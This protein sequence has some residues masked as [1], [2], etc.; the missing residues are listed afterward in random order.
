MAK[1]LKFLSS[2]ALAAVSIVVT[3]CGGHTKSEDTVDV[4]D[5]KYVHRYGVAVPSDF[6]AAS[7]EH[8]LVVSTLADGVVVTR[9]YAS[10]T[11]DGET[12]FT[13]PHSSQI[14]K[15]QIYQ[16]GTLVQET[17][18]FFDGTPKLQN[19]YHSPDYG[20]TS[21]YTWYLSG[22]PKSIERYQDNNLMTGEYFTTLNQR[23]SLVEDMQG[24]R[25]NR[26]D[27]GQLQSTDI[28]EN[29]QMVLR[30][31]Y[32][33]NGSPRE[34]I[35]Y[36]NGLIDGIKRTYHPAGEPDTIEQW[37]IGQQDGMTVVFQ[38]GEKYSE[39]PYYNGEKHGVECRYR[40]GQDKVKEISWHSGQLNGPSTT[41]VGD[42]I[43]TDWYY[44]G[45]P[46]SKADYEFITNRPIVR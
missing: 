29:G 11:L 41:Y 7:G 14:Q 39:V 18:Y 4:I 6:W 31:T 26:D 16:A 21:M 19:I 25:L 35:P 15:K 2:A 1:I 46:V 23:D 20:T 17:E 34:T 32:H 13:Y 33:P 8:G 24:S 37:S 28:I 45:K 43:K 30:H 36:R 10:G 27:Y 38:H 9:S 5:E 22:T 12:T 3:A 44:K 40:D 42:N